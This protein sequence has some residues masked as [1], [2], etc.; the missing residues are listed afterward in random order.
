MNLNVN[1]TLGK[2]KKN[3]SILSGLGLLVLFVI[4]YSLDSFFRNSVDSYISKYFTGSIYSETVTVSDSSNEI[5]DL[6]YNPVEVIQSSP[7]VGDTLETLFSMLGTPE[8]ITTE[9]S[10]TIFLYKTPK[11]NTYY[12]IKN[13]IITKVSTSSF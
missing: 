5:I 10:E 11:Q 4:S 12:F 3:L 7:R 6:S 1:V 8:V 13:N 2:K 9:N